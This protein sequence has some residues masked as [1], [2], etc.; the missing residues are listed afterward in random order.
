M[1]WLGCFIRRLGYR[2]LILHEPG[3]YAL[4]TTTML[5]QPGVGIVPHEPPVGAHQ[6]NGVAECAVREVKRQVRALRYAL[7]E[8]PS[9]VGVIADA[10][11]GCHLLVQDR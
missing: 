5:A 9:S 3:V 7:E 11:R 1:K 6:A 8:G 10:G 4:K 2:R